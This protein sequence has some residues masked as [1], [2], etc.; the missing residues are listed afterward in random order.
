MKCVGG[1][2]ARG[3]GKE[4]GQLLGYVLWLS[5]GVLL[6]HMVRVNDEVSACLNLRGITTAECYDAGKALAGNAL[7]KP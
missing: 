5:L 6:P 3:H 7:P 2:A 1:T 4:K